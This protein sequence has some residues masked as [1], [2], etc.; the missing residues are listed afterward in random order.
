LPE[1]A[2]R[3]VAD[4]SAAVG[5]DAAAVALP[6]LAVMAAAV[7]NTYRARIKAGWTEPAVLWSGI[8]CESGTG[9]TPAQQAV[10]QP[11][12]QREQEA[13]REH[14]AAV[15]E[16]ERARQLY[17]RDLAAWKRSKEGGEPPEEPLPPVCRRL[18]VT[19]IT[20]EALALRLA[21]NPRGLLVAR[22]ELAG[23]LQSFRQYK[24]KGAGDDSPNW[25]SAHN[26]GPWRV[27]R[28]TGNQYLYIPHAA[29]SVTGGIQPKA[30]RRVLTPEYF[31]NGLAARLLLAMPPRQ[32]RQWREAEVSEATRRAWADL[33]ARLYSL[34]MPTDEH[35]AP[36]PGEISLS[37]DGRRAF[38]AFVNEHAVE[39]YETTSGDLAALWSKLEGTAARCALVFHLVRVMGDDA[40]LADCDAIDAQSVQ[41]GVE[42]VRWFGREARRLYHVLSETE[43]EEGQRE[44]VE[45][46]ARLGGEVTARDLMRARQT[47]YQ[48]A[49]QAEEALTDLAANELGDWFTVEHPGPG[50]P[51]AVFRLRQ[52]AGN[53]TISDFCGKRPIVSYVEHYVPDSGGF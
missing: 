8:V 3:F 44:L 32:A 12:E 13:A 9:K 5:C 29:V 42:L 49:E 20:V 14:A 34:P 52:P 16:Y 10:M 4:T 25:L 36:R 17:E 6:A 45:L 43:E 21:E 23:W 48:T 11:V 35:G 2:R 39:Q 51:T 33:L 38:V 19:D 50:R 46:I 37:A 31:D 30:L 27:D 24:A 18:V 41:A 7:G 28:R 15:I 40:T 22:D 26:A 1:P 53:D 47:V